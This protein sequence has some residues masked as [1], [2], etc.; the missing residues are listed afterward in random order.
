MLRITRIIARTLHSASERF[1]KKEPG[2]LTTARRGEMEAY[3]HLK[4]QGYRVV[5]KNFRTPH[6][7]G[8][9]DLVAWDHGVLCFVEVK[10]HAQP[11]LVPPEIAVDAAKKQHVLSV[12]RRYVR[13]LP[14]NRPPSCR[15]DVVSVVLGA[16]R[17]KPRIKLYKGAFA[18]KTSGHAE[19]TPYVARDRKRW[20]RH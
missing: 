17:S 1:G 12:A 18:W 10:T 4:D 20:W 2:H 7:R 5:A 11:G 9:I 19:R 6:N 3:F 16:D 8:E 13:R 14:G 15:F